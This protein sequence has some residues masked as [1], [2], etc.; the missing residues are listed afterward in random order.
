MLPAPN[1]AGGG[2]KNAIDSAFRVWL[3][4]SCDG[5]ECKRWM[6]CD[7]VGGH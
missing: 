7:N 2:I 3:V 4:I 6:K 5:G 1:N